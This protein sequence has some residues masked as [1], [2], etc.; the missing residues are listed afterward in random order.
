MKKTDAEVQIA[1]SYGL[2]AF[3]CHTNVEN[4]ED[5]SKHTIALGEWMKI[6]PIEFERWRKAALPS[7]VETVSEFI[8]SFDRSIERSVVGVPL[9][10]NREEQRQWSRDGNEDLRSLRHKAKLPE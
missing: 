8:S 7:V 3:L 9:S 5:I 10:L 1:I 6:R 2:E 4:I